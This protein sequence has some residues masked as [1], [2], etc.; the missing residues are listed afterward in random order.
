MFQFLIGISKIVQFSS[1][2]CVAKCDKI[3]SVSQIC[4][5]QLCPKCRFYLHFS[6]YHLIACFYFSII[7]TKQRKETKQHYYRR[8]KNVSIKW[9]CEQWKRMKK[10]SWFD[11]D[12]NNDN[13]NNDKIDSFKQSSRFSGIKMIWSHN[14]MFRFKFGNWPNQFDSKQIEKLWIPNCA[15]CVYVVC[16][17]AHHHFRSVKL[18]HVNMRL[19]KKQHAETQRSAKVNLCNMYRVPKNWCASPSYAHRSAFFSTYFYT[20]LFIIA[21]ISLLFTLKWMCENFYN[22]ANQHAAASRFFFEE[23]E[24]WEKNVILIRMAFTQEGNSK[25]KQ[26]IW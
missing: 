8:Q 16:N 5:F 21:H 12:S 2:H 24:E 15:R 14:S 3:E 25:F 6:P 7:L 9:W 11:V 19:W 22:C 10:I 23:E 26:I 13:N 17:F 4:R 1:T 20:L 18:E